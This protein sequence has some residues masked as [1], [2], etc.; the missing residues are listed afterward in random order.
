[1]GNEEHQPYDRSS[2]WLIQHHGDSMLRLA[3]I[4]GIEA[5]RPAQAE[6]VQPRQLP[7]GL[8]EVRL[9]GETREEAFLL[10]VATFPE[11]RVA[12]QLTR[13]LMLVY[14]DRREL[15]ETVTL[16]LRPKGKYRIPTRRNLRSRR[17]LS[18]CSMKW[19]V[20]EL[21]T[22]PA[23]RLLETQDV[24]LI[25]WVPLTDFAEP[26]EAVIRRCRDVIEEHAPAGERANLLAVTQVLT[27]L[28]YNDAGLL[29]A[30]LPILGGR[31]VMIESPLI[32][33][34]VAENTQRS[35]LVFLETRFGEVPHEIAERIQSITDQDRLTELVRKAASCAD[36]EE[37]QKDMEN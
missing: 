2:K 3:R 16:V 22:V 25:P 17:G 21:W 10:E 4:E 37:F 33:E 8:L 24:G 23:E 1:M 36:L 7:D 20:V 14:L 29:S 18:S 9:A 26:P 35:I 28:R 34:L 19:H 32:Q 15:P 12:E 30:L 11:Q 13:D 31:E 6:I 5:W 27:R